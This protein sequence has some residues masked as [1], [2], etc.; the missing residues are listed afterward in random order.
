MIPASFYGFLAKHLQK[1]FGAKIKAFDW[2]LQEDFIL[3]RL[4]PDNFIK[5]PYKT[6]F[7]I[8]KVIDMFIDK[9]N[10]EYREPYFT[11]IHVFPPHIPYLAPE[12]YADLFNSSQKYRTG[13]SQDDLVRPRYFAQEQ[14]PDA[15]IIRARYDAFIRYSDKEFQDFIEQLEQKAD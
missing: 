8:R 15:D 13:Q 3:N 14:Q 1:L 10:N 5:Y 12:Q 9:I 4:V 6:Q 7:P 2:I 11:W